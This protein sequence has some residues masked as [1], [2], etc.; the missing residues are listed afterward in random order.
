MP[1]VNELPFASRR[2]AVYGL[3][4]M[5]A[6]SQPLAVTAGLEL[7]SQGGNAADAAIASAAALN[8]TEPTSTGLGGDCFAL[9][10]EARS[11]LISALNG[12]GRAPAALS[13]ARLKNEGFE[14]EL[15]PYHPYTITVPGA[16]AGWCDL[17]AR[18][19]RLSMHQVLAP[20]IRLAEQGFPVSPITAYHWN[21]ATKR[22]V[23]VPGGIEMT[24]NGRAPRAGEIFHNHGL[25]R[26]MRTIAEA[27]KSTFY[28]GEIAEAIVRVVQQA[29]GCLTM[30]DLAAHSSTWDQ[31]IST[32]YRGFRVWEC[33]PNGQ[34]LAALLALNLL[35]GYDLACLP[36]LSSQRLHLMI[37]AMRLA[38]ADT[39]WYVA[40]PAFKPAPLDWLLCKEY[41]SERRRLIHPDHATLDQHHSTPTSSSDTVYLTVVDADGNACSFINSNY[42]GFGTGIVPTGW[43][44]TLQ[45]RGYGFSLE[46]SHPNALAP[47]KRPYHTIIPAMI[48]ID[49]PEPSVIPNILYASFGVMGGLMQPQGHVQV[50]VALVDDRADPQAALDRPR[51]CIEDGHAGGL[52]ALEE[53][54]PAAVLSELK[55]MG[56]SVT[57]LGGYARSTF[58][59]GQIIRREADTGVLCGGS[60]PRADGC[61]LS[62]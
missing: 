52:V 40:D 58:G 24:I 49:A 36:T 3:G 19:G 60:D 13:I 50:V 28:Q 62:L 2:S 46:P 14:Q 6:T 37:E 35:E 10:Y 53:G 31:P 61:A 25:A 4:G 41:A 9:Y 39:R 30:D 51:F 17:L 56:H 5:V 48:T 21:T 34:G 27:G 55:E 7:L 59:R 43:G 23:S 42:Y 15:P 29:G 38:F 8:V 22:L 45:N 32:T 44:F 18:H 54:I 12:S 26:T 57:T 33:P 1:A 16:C 47:G 11:G 20:A